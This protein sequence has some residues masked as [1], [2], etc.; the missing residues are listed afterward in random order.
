MS[1]PADLASRGVKVEY[2][3]FSSIWWFG[4][5]FLKQDKFCWPNSNY[6]I[7]KSELPEIKKNA[8]ILTNT[9]QE[10]LYLFTKFSNYIKLLR[11]TAL[12]IRFFKNLCNKK[13]QGNKSTEPITAIELDYVKTVL[14]NVSQHECFREELQT[15]SKNACLN[16]KHSLSS[17]VPFIDDSGVLRVGGRLRN[18]FLPYETKHPVVLHS[19]HPFTRLIFEYK[20]KVLLH[21]G[22]QLLLSSV[23]Q[24]Y[25]PIG[26][27]NLAK[28]TVRTCL[29]CFKFNPVPYT[30]PMSNLPANR[31]KFSLPFE[32]T[33]VDYVGPFQILNR[34]GR[35]AKLFKCYLVI[36]VCFS[37]KA[38]HLEVVTNLTTEHFLWCYK[39]FT[40]RRLIPHDL[41]SDNGSTFIGARNEQKELG[42]FI[43][44]NQGYFVD[45]TTHDNINWHFIPPY[46]PNFGGLWESAVKSAKHHL[47]RIMLNHNVTLEEFITLKTQVEGILNSRPLYAMSND[48]N[49]NSPITPSHFLIG[50][51]ITQVPELT[52]Q[53]TKFNRLSRLQHMQKLC[54]Q[55]WRQFSNTT[56]LSYITSINGKLQYATY[57]KEL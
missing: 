36:F 23:R 45:V 31:I 1:N 57:K 39:R 19:K 43:L 15:L 6:S 34:P 14:V 27:C 55:F 10:P 2:L 29:T 53:N 51:P 21:P 49:D 28:K 11:I 35:G 3:S 46:T 7:P 44:K 8:I 16:K 20:H 5:Q 26:G 32:T 38:V 41:Y 47:K 48:P 22:P 25:W 30:S 50:R 9:F 40:S 54:Q 52:L 42:R 13:L 18:T 56:Y 17:L 4:P 24:F 12:C 37:T 33:G